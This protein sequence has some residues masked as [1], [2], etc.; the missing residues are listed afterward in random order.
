MCFV[1]FPEKKKNFMA[2]I[3][4]S[5]LSRPLIIRN[6]LLASHKN[7]LKK[8]VTMAIGVAFSKPHAE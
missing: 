8:A 2:R 7:G 6:A 3:I 5:V 1:N 4:K